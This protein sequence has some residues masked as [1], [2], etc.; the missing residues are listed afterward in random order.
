VSFERLGLLAVCVSVVVAACGSGEA[1]SPAAPRVSSTAASPSA[2]QTQLENFQRLMPFYYA[3]SNVNIDPM[4]FL[5]KPG[6]PAGVGPLMVSHVA[7]IAPAKQGASPTSPLLGADGK[8]LGIMLGQWE[9]A[10]GTVAFSCVASRE[11]ATST[12]TGLIPSA[13]YSTFVVHLD[14]EGSGRFTPWGDPAGTTNSFTA[15]ATGTAAPTNTV[16]G[17]LGT[18]AAAAIIWHSDATTHGKSPGDIGVN[19]HTSLITRVP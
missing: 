8:Q 1:P 17:C 5:P 9:K 13:T 19:W 16:K 14:V 15:S 11:R 6:A 2:D 3:E 10:A 4:V 18:D 12:L 7:G